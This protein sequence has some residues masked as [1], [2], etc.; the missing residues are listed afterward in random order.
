MYIE[1]DENEKM[2]LETAK[3]QLGFSSYFEAIDSLA[4]IENDSEEP[5]LWAACQHTLSGI[6]A[7]YSKWLN[8]PKKGKHKFVIKEW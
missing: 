5:E 1:P 3:A 8:S 6:I 7:A 2:A 4:T